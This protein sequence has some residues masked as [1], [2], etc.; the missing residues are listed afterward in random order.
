M[1]EKGEKDLGHRDAERKAKGRRA[2]T[3]VEQLQARDRPGLVR[4]HQEPGH[5]PGKEFSLSF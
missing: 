1:Y 5:S 4:S 2:D 3:G